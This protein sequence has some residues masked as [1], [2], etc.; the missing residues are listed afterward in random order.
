MKLL[1]LTLPTPEHNLALD[2]ALLDACDEL[3][4][5]ETLR[6][7]EPATYFVVAGYANSLSREVNLA[8]CEELDLPVLRRCSGGGTVL[9]GPGCV[10]YSLVLRLDHHPALAGIHSAN[11]WIM[12]R[13]RS[14]VS[15][16]LGR[17][18]SVRGHTDLAIEEMKF[19][20]NAQRRKRGA[21]L[22]HG[23]FL[24]SMDLAMITRT[25]RSPSKQPDYRAHR[26]HEKF[27]CNLSV[28]QEI[29]TR[30]LAHEWSADEKLDT[31]PLAAVESLVEKRYSRRDWNWKFP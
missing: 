12:E 5:P 23:A 7:W 19:S 15:R 24:V 26:D 4:A 30:A 18:A 29:L 22:F 16:V 9:Q 27:L 3:N 8:A 21:L 17:E 31:F 6:I 25:L 1:N 11:C 20:G 13:Q 2:E 28:D 10:N 14:A